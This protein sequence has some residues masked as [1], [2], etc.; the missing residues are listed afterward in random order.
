MESFIPEKETCPYCNSMG[1][2]HIHAYYFRNLLWFDGTSQ[3]CYRLRILRVKCSGCGHT[4]AIL[5]DVII[6]YACYGIQFILKVLSEHLSKA[7]TAGSVCTKYGISQALFFRWLR[8]LRKD[9]RIFLGLLNNQTTALSDFLQNI[10]ASDFC[11]FS[12]EFILLTAR[13]FLQVHK[14]PA[15]YR[16][17]VF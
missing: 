6:P 2:C 8:I 14:N 15:I 16:Q 7:S 9:K 5:P 12:A 1:N 4:H 10:L 11:N 17:T 13:S 3:V